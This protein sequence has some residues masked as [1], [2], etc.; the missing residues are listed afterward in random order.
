MKKRKQ[1][2]IPNSLRRCRKVAGLT[3]KQVADRMNLLST[4]EISRWESGR[5]FPNTENFID[6]AAIYGCPLDKL[7]WEFILNRRRAMNVRKS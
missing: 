2:F 3:Q 1:K 4:A 6:L 5:C 7:Y